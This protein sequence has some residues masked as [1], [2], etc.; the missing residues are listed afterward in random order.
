MRTLPVLKRLCVASVG[1]VAAALLW[2]CWIIP[3][4]VDQFDAHRD[5]SAALP[6]FPGAQG[7]GTDTIAGRGGEVVTV[8]SLEASGTGTLRAALEDVEG[9]RTIVFEVGG[10]IDLSTNIV[11]SEPFVSVAGQ[12]APD[13]GITIIGAGIVVHTHDVLIQ[14]IAMRPGDRSEG[15]DPEGRDAIGVVGDR[16]GETEVYNVVVD[17]CSISWAIDEGASTWYG[18]VQDVT[19]SNCIISEQLSRSLHPEREHSKGLL[20]GDHARRV[21]VIGNLFAHNM[22]RNPMLKGNTSSLVAGNLIYNPGTAAIDFSDRERS[23]PARSSIIGNVLIRGADTSEWMSMI[24]LAGR[25]Y[26]TMQIYHADN[27]ELAPERVVFGPS[28]EITA[29]VVQQPPVTLEPLD[30]PASEEVYEAVLTNAGMR[31]WKHDAVDARVVDSVRE[32]TGA[33]I[34]SQDDVGGFPEYARTTRTLVVPDR[35]N[36]DD[37]EDGYT[38]LEEWIWGFTQSTTDG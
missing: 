27:I 34:D 33:I 28:P 9:P 31:P 12:T 1:I 24:S 13:P 23:G 3:P 32:R 19:F 35:P 29:V 26:D 8:T 30:L 10:V 37:D 15:P 14:H 2:G 7:F 6:V 17:H 22:R 25:V 16:R 11:I 5:L 20:I 4:D 18:G 21:A 36:D 38:N